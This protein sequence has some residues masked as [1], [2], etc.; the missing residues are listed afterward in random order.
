MSGPE[1]GFGEPLGPEDVFSSPG[2]GELD[3]GPIAGRLVRECEAFRHLHEGEA[4][5]LFLMREVPK[6][7]ACRMVLGEM[8]LP[9]F[10][11]ALGP[12]ACWLLARLCNGMPDFVMVLDA[13]WWVQAPPIQREALVFHELEHAIHARDRDG[14]LKF[15]PDGR[16]VWALRGHDL[17]EFDSVVRR[18]GAWLPDVQRFIGALRDGNAI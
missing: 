13:A 4:T 8:C 16:P 1:V 14:E 3:P 12:V 5:I 11:G 7:K 10:G 17:E 18:Y 6:E 2:D 9:K 15:D